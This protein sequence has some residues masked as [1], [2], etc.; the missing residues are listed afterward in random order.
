M[1]DLVS[2]ALVRQGSPGHRLEEGAFR[3]FWPARGHA[4]RQTMITL[5][6][7]L[8]TE[9]LLHVRQPGSRDDQSAEIAGG[10]LTTGG[11]NDVNMWVR[12]VPMLARDPRREAT[13]AAVGGQLGHR[14]PRESL[15]VKTPGVPGREDESIDGPLAGHMGGRVANR[16]DNVSPGHRSSGLDRWRVHGPGDAGPIA[17]RPPGTRRPSPDREG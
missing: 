2:E 5:T 4:E 11:Q 13:P 10:L 16:Q 17:W 12:R 1:V 9:S 14:G 15:Q 7:H 6:S 3:P 8:Q